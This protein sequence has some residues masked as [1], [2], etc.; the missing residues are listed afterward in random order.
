MFWTLD[1]RTERVFLHPQSSEDATLLEESLEIFVVYSFEEGLGEVFLFRESKVWFFNAF[2]T[3]E[4][5][6][7]FEESLEFWVDL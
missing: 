1:R 4:R 5:E 7:L 6:D 2:V 3:N